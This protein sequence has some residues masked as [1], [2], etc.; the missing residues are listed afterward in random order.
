MNRSKQKYDPLTRNEVLFRGITTGLMFLY[1]LGSSDENIGIVLFLGVMIF[2]VLR[3]FFPSNP[4]VVCGESLYV[5]VLSLWMPGLAYV[6]LLPIFESFLMNKAI[7][8]LPGFIIG[9]F[10]WELNIVLLSLFAFTGVIGV[11]FRIA[12]QERDYYKEQYDLERQSKYEAER[13]NDELIFFQNEALKMV[14]LSERDRIAQQLHD[15]VGHELT[16]AVLGLQAYAALLEERSVNQYEKDLFDKINNR[17]FNSAKL[18]RQTVHNM[19]PYVTIG[20]DSFNDLIESY[21]DLSIKVNL[22]GDLEKVPAYYWILLNKALKEGLTNIMRHAKA[23]EA[24]VQLDVTPDLVRLSI[25]NEILSAG[26]NQPNLNKGM[27]LRSLKR[28]ALSYGGS[29]SASGVKGN[30]F[31]VV[32]V[33]PLVKEGANG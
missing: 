27:G 33:L 13:F 21:D 16:G 24:T 28:Q 15:D 32:I 29:F 18:L 20:I 7:L 3:Y 10:K 17:V 5:A 2:S 8:I 30:H 4:S 14:E 19:K 23:L 26:K 6:F 9:I 31:L 11:F 1:W 25:K 12:K 22:Y